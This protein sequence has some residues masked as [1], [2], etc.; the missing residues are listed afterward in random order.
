[1]LATCVKTQNRMTTPFYTCGI[2]DVT[3]V[4]EPNTVKY[5]ND[6]RSTKNHHMINNMFLIT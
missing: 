5:T 4:D 2:R 6:L 3:F 1:M